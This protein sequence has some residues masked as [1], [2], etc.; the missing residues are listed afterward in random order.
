MLNV[1]FTNVGR[2]TYLIE[3]AVR[4]KRDGYPIKIFVTDT[5][6]YTAGF[7]VSKDI[8]SLITMKVKGNEKKYADQLLKLCKKNKIK[9]VIP[10]MDFEL[11]VLSS[12][13]ERF[14]KHG[15]TIIISDKDIVKK[16][17][18]K[19]ENFTFCLENNISMPKAYFLKKKL[20]EKYPFI[21]KRIYGS[22]SEGLKKIN[23]RK[24]FSDFKEGRDMLQEFIKGKEY[25]MNI[26]NDL[27]GNFVHAS[28]CEKLLMRTGETDKA[29]AV[30][31]QKLMSL[32]K[33]ISKKFKH[34][35]HM[36][37]DFIVN[38]RNKIHFIDFNPRFG[39]FYPIAYLAGYD[40]LKYILDMVQQKKFKIP[41]KQ[42]KIFFVKGISLYSSEN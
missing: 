33:T 14:Q 23:S 10:L 1:L 16:C 28:F 6:K 7:Y 19:K 13:K 12:Q 18:D 36:D 30:Y 27:E 9:V 31:S 25:G 39:G 5:S 38:K 32:A 24:D 11:I 22:G 35:G 8:I 15:I 26:L 42:K 21:Q 29:I 37:V 41:K 40:Y 34:V 17:L 3:N 20:P 4:L 2:R